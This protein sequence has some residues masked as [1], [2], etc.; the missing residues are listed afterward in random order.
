MI[1]YNQYYQYQFNIYLGCHTI[2]AVA[3]RNMYGYI[4]R[5]TDNY[6]LESFDMLAKDSEIGQWSRHENEMK[7]RTQRLSWFCLHLHLCML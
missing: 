6:Q 3:D 7:P 2:L 5:N 4:L 1:A